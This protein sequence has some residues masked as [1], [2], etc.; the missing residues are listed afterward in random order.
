MVVEREDQLFKVHEQLMALSVPLDGEPRVGDFRVVRLK[1]RFRNPLFNG[2]RDAL[3]N[4]AVYIGNG[5][6]VVC[7]VQLHLGAVLSHKEESYAAGTRNR[8]LRI[9][10]NQIS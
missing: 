1:N 10:T 7:E 2:Y 9:H 6:W 5:V 4:I 3:Y 8:G